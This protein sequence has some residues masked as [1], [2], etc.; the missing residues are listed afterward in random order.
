MSNIRSHNTH[1]HA[2]AMRAEM[3]RPNGGTGVA[4]FK[5]SQKF[6]CSVL[7]LLI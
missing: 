6:V 2:D 1:V 5:L 4:K 3:A 7:Q